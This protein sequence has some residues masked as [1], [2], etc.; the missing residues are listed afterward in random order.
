MS[1]RHRTS[2]K[3]NIAKDLFDKYA[4]DNLAHKTDT[5]LH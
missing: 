2:L 3:L 4:E 1:A 5:I